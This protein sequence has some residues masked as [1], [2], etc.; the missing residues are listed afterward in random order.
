MFC[1]SEHMPF[2]LQEVYFST[3]WIVWLFSSRPYFFLVF[4][5]IYLEII[6]PVNS[7]LIWFDSYSYLE[8]DVCWVS[9]H[10]P[11]SLQSEIINKMYT[12]RNFW[13]HNLPFSF[14]KAC[15]AWIFIYFRV[16][17]TTICPKQKSRSEWTGHLNM[18]HFCF[19]W[20]N[21]K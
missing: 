14:C 16:E 2:S 1:V 11:F 8:V 4:K 6:S 13:K 9:K 15:L 18:S 3:S 12:L 7:N 19:Q 17:R 20:Q 5:L 10:E 21:D